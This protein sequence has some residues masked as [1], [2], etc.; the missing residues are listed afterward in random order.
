M[1]EKQNQISNNDKVLEK[2]ET[3]EDKNAVPIPNVKTQNEETL[4][5][6]KKENESNVIKSSSS[7]E[8]EKETKAK[9]KL[10]TF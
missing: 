1:I 5:E 4:E 2:T 3:I 6:K 9:C 10:T 7:S 8:T